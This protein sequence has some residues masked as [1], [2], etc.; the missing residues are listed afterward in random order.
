MRKILVQL[1]KRLIQFKRPGR[2]LETFL[3][4]KEILYKKNIQGFAK[5]SF[6][7]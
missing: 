2:R 6:I 5:C 3:E 1:L 7:I 4:Q